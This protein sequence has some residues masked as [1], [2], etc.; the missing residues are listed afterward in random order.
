MWLLLF[1]SSFLFLGCSSKTSII[2]SNA[3][4]F[5]NDAVFLFKQSKEEASVISLKKALE[6]YKSIDNIDSQV[7]TLLLLFKITNNKEYL[8]NAELFL[9]ISSL[10]IDNKILFAK[11]LLS[12]DKQIFVKL[13][14]SK[15]IEIKTLS[16]IYLYKITKMDKYLNKVSYNKKDFIYSFYLV[17]LF[18]KTQNI[19]LLKEAL[20]IDKE[21]ESKKFI[22]RDLYKLSKYYKLL[23]VKLSYLYKVRAD[24]IY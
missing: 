1:L 5:K 8:E 17:T 9:G 13:I 16:L 4:S 19:K 12:M 18:D 22:K 7:E 3:D 2:E 14:N 21:F 15:D 23:D 11:A 20:A 6:I 10:E 24:G